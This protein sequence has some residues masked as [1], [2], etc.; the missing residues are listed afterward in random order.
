MGHEDNRGAAASFVSEYKK[1]I[2]N[3]PAM[4]QDPHQPFGSGFLTR[5]SLLV[6]RYLPI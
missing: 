1:T 2:R 5:Y 3:A 6:T 4:S